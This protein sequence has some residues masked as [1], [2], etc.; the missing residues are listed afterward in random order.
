VAEYTVVAALSVADAKYKAPFIASAV[1]AVK[2][3]RLTIVGEPNWWTAL[4]ASALK[5]VHIACVFAM[6]YPYA[7]LP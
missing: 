1:G 3:V 2:L 5:L 4:S 7:K 6:I